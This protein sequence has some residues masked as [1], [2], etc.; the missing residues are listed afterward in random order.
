M[1]GPGVLAWV[2]G[3][4]VGIVLLNLAGTAGATWYAPAAF[5]V[6]F[7]SYLGALLMDSRV[8]EV[9]VRPHDPRDEVADPWESRIRCH[10]CGLSYVAQEMDRDPSAGHHAI[11]CECAARSPAFLAAAR[12][13]SAESKGARTSV[14]CQLGIRVFVFFL[15]RTPEVR[16]MLDR[17][18]R[19]LQ[20]D[21]R[22]EPPFH[23]VVA[24]GRARVCSGRAASSH[25]VFEAPAKLF[26]RMMLDT[27]AADEAYV[28]KK[29]EVHGSPADAT[30]FRTLAER[31]QGHHPA[32]F[33]L[34][35]K[36]GPVLVGVS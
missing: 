36:V 17:W 27:A 5:G 13:E 11:C 9:P 14:K 21:L 4:V 1:H 15:N 35:R 29:Y 30:R 2:L 8:G 7:L 16:D 33:G 18:D 25:V 22:G 23:V 10:A 31:V 12:R 20:F 32:V 19:T 6:S 24:G 34:L 28:N 3:T 26:L